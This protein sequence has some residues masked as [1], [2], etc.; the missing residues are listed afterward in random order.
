MEQFT[1][2]I[3]K[4]IFSAIDKKWYLQINKTVEVV[5]SEKNAKELISKFSLAE[6]NLNR[7]EFIV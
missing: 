4:I 3:T 5:I 1:L 6:T 7:W 2:K